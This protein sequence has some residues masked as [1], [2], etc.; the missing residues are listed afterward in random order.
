M[1]MLLTSADYGVYVVA[2][3]SGHMETYDTVVEPDN[4]DSTAAFRILDVKLAIASWYYIIN[5]W[6][7]ENMF[8]Y[9][10]MLLLNSRQPK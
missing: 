7:L 5:L 6:I 3:M 2:N 9:L 1:R 10:M 8:M 4:V